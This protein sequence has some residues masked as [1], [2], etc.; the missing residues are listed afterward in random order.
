MDLTS[1]KLASMGQ[2]SK[3]EQN[4]RFK[5]FKAGTLRED[6]SAVVTEEQKRIILRNRCLPTKGEVVQNADQIRSPFLRKKTPANY[7]KA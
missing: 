3:E 7:I 4:K 2:L 1:K 5:D 6:G